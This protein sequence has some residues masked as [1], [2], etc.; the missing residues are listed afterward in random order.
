MTA[1]SS[2]NNA[3][4]RV[5]WPDTIQHSIASFNMNFKLW[6]GMVENSAISLEFSIKRKVKFPEE[7]VGRCLL[8]TP[9]SKI[10]VIVIRGSSSLLIS[11]LD[12]G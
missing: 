4:A 8:E 6:L 2:M 10:M 5:H 12:T 11:T 7:G 1:T 9:L 3:F